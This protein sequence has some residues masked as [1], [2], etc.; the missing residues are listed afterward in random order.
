MDE[1]TVWNT[2]RPKQDEEREQAI[3][4]ARRIL[5]NHNPAD[6]HAVLAR[7]FLRA[8]ALPEVE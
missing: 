5:A 2:G 4:V 1:T 7:Q 3:A 6:P 8:L